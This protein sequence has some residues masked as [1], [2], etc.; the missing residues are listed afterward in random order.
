MWAPVGYKFYTMTAVD[1]LEWN[2]IKCWLTTPDQVVLPVIRTSTADLNIV[3]ATVKLASRR[4]YII[5]WSSPQSGP[6]TAW[7]EVHTKNS[8]GKV[9]NSV[10]KC[11]MDASKPATQTRSSRE[12]LSLGRNLGFYGKRTTSNNLGMA[13]LEIRRAA[14]I[15]ISEVTREERIFSID[16]VPSDRPDIGTPYITFSFNFELALPES[17][18]TPTPMGSPATARLTGEQHQEESDSKYALRSQVHISSSESS[19]SSEYSEDEDEAAEAA[20]KK[21]G[22]R[23]SAKGVASKVINP[24]DTDSDEDVNGSIA[25]KPVSRKRALDTATA[26]SSPA[27]RAKKTKIASPPPALPS[28]SESMSV[29]P[30]SPSTST[31]VSAKPPSP[32]ASTAMSFS[33]IAQS[34]ANV[35]SPLPTPMPTPVTGTGEGDFDV[36]MASEGDYDVK[37]AELDDEIQSHERRLTLLAERQ[38]YMEVKQERVTLLISIAAAEEAYAALPTTSTPAGATPANTNMA[39]TAAAQLENLDDSDGDEDYG[40]KRRRI[41]AE[42]P[43]LKAKLLELK[44]KI[45]Y[46]E[47][48]D[49]LR[50]LQ[51]EIR[52]MEE[53][54]ERL[55]SDITRTVISRP[56]SSSFAGSG[57]ASAPP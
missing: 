53:R 33:E 15:T 42:L 31:A 49:R 1:M 25:T 47:K 43:P 4:S 21:R 3:T 45:R 57:T 24:A 6:L 52:A 29:K 22:P 26:K 17:T 35:A 51:E 14:S 44:E 36:K 20:P 16:W 18:H 38:K 54:C 11:E 40:A 13:W 32:V 12:G 37:M 50:K 41:E 39:N 56:G 55:A 46:R 23:A 10:A 48:Q 9:F 19:A 30:L 34:N 5:H 28:E 8:H 7:C 27:R 2:G